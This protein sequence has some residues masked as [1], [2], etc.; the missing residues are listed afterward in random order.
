MLLSIQRLLVC[1]IAAT[2]VSAC[3]GQPTDRAVDADVRAIVR[4]HLPDSVEISSLDHHIVDGN[5]SSLELYAGVVLLPRLDRVVERGPF[6]G[7]RLSRSTK[8][9]R[10]A[11]HL[12]Y[13]NR[14]TSWVLHAF[15]VTLPGQSKRG[16]VWETQND[17]A[18]RGT[19][20]GDE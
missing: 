15:S 6:Q 4:Q 20:R 17:R 14:E 1:L 3:G 13:R 8:T 11:L 2:A 18:Q 16:P 12:F 7:L 5:D 19:Q 9:P 10:V